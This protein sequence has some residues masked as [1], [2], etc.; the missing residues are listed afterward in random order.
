MDLAHDEGIIE[1]ARE[2]AHRNG[3]LF[4][5]TSCK[6]GSGVNVLEQNHLW[7]SL[8]EDI[9]KYVSVKIRSFSKDTNNTSQL[10]RSNIKDSRDTNPENQSCCWYCLFFWFYHEQLNFSST[11]LRHLS[12]S[13][14]CIY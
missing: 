12:E 5:L 9:A 10:L 4:H 13:R 11:G 14:K 3:Y 6:D 2:M 1:E 7:K 8:F